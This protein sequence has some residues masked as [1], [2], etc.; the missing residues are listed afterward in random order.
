MKWL[1]CEATGVRFPYIW[2]ELTIWICVIFWFLGLFVESQSNGTNAMEGCRYVEPQGI[3]YKKI[4]PYLV[5]LRPKKDDSIVGTQPT[6]IKDLDL[7]NVK[8]KSICSPYILSRA[9]Y[10][11][12]PSYGGVRTSVESSQALYRLYYT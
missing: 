9:T 2:L 11:G 12:A 4:G 10:P 1:L 6:Q 3:R 8:K 5:Y 7:K